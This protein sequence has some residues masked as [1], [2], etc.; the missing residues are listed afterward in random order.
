MDH[1][2][3]SD[4]CTCLCNINP[5]HDTE[6]YH[7]LRNSFLCVPSQSVLTPTP[8]GAY[9]WSWGDAHQPQVCPLLNRQVL[10]YFYVFFC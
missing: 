4:K 2:M 10:S 9:E 1:R 3:N 8:G 6:H 5:Y 7:S